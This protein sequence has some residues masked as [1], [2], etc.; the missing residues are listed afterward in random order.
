ML[1]AESYENELG[2]AIAHSLMQTYFYMPADKP[3][4][5]V[6]MSEVDF[7]VISAGGPST[8]GQSTG[9]SGAGDSEVCD[10]NGLM[11]MITIGLFR[12]SHFNSG[13]SLALFWGWPCC[14]I[15]V[16]NRLDLAGLASYLL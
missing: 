2:F 4:R 8:G 1:L 14:F 9:D 13:V 5:D 7:D 16:P 15:F 11:V 10:N 3:K 12:F 6:P